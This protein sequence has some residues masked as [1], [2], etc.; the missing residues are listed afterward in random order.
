MLALSG[1]GSAD[2]SHFGE[3]LQQMR[4]LSLYQAEM[5]VSNICAVWSREGNKAAKGGYILGLFFSASWSWL[6]RAWKSNLAL[7]LASCRILL[8]H[9]TTTTHCY[10]KKA[11]FL[12]NRAMLK[13]NLT[14]V[15]A[16]SW[17]KKCFGWPT[18][19]ADPKLFSPLG[20]YP[21]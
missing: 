19:Q 16:T 11:L 18:R 20:S 9:F 14:L 7:T 8:S 10:K 21:E 13:H 5:S 3:K 4:Q 15:V 6:P 17:S 1:Q 12:G 2:Y